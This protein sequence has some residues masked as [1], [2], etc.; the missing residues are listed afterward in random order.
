MCVQRYMCHAGT[1]PWMGG[2]H[3]Y[4]EKGRVESLRMVVPRLEAQA[5]RKADGFVGSESLGQM[6]KIRKNGRPAFFDETQFYL[7]Q[8][9]AIEAAPRCFNEHFGMN[10]ESTPQ[11]GRSSFRWTRTSSIPAPPWSEYLDVTHVFF[12]ERTMKAE[13]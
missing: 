11:M 10:R 7:F 3:P 9:D 12:V 4:Y 2:G 8:Y 1:L 13:G 6:S 5:L